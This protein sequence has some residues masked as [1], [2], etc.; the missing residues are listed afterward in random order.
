VT[1]VD[2]VDTD[3]AAW[4]VL[5]ANH[6]SINLCFAG[7]TINWTTDQWMQQ[8]KAIDVAAYLCI[9]DCVKYGISTKVLVPPYT[10]DP[11][12]IS[13]HKYVTQHLGSGTHTD[14]GSFFPWPYFQQR[15]AF[16]NQALT[17][18]GPPPTQDQPD[19]PVVPYDPT[20]NAPMETLTQV[21][22]RWGRLGKRTLVEA[23]GVI[24]DKVTGED[25]SKDDSFS[26]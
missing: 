13:D 16:W 24:L 25:N 21:R 22:V 17:T 19:H 15:I 7:S 4:A 3:D 20:Q 23:V 10:S 2:C 5:D 26:W 6:R 9:Q 14:V 1:V 12:G 11:P 18:T 8:S